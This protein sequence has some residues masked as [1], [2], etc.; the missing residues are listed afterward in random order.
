MI[1]KLAERHYKVKN[2]ITS[3]TTIAIVFAIVLGF[4][5]LFRLLHN[6]KKR[7]RLALQQEKMNESIIQNKLEISEKEQIDNYLLAIDKTNFM[8]MYIDYSAPGNAPILMDLWQI[9]NVKIVTEHNDVYEEKKGKK[10]L[11]DKQVIKLMIQVT[12][13]DGKAGQEMVL[14]DY[15]NAIREFIHSKTRAAY[16]CQ[17][18]NQALLELPPSRQK[19]KTVVARPAVYF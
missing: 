12:L 5:L 17:L 14:Y 6:K 10:I 16:W 8:L 3:L 1:L 11:V 19:N 13:T 15:N 2:M 18:I 7:S 4:I 9:K